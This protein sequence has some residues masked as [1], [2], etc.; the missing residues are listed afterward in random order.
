MSITTAERIDIEKLFVLMFNAAPGA[1]Y[2]GQI[3]TLYESVGH[4]LQAVANILDDT[5]PFQSL[6]PNFLTD[7]EF[8]TQFLTPLGLQNDA[9]ARSFVIAKV[10]A[11]VPKGEIIYEALQALKTVGTGSAS[12][13][14]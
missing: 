3:V 9:L 6:Y 4:N 1:T 2:L 7:A 11:G 10:D 14:I 13:Y 5:P 12:Q 8:A